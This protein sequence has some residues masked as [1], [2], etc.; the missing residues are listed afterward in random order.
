ME[1]RNRES[2]HIIFSYYRISR[3]REFIESFRAERSWAALQER[4][5]VRRRDR[6]RAIG[7]R[8]SA[9]AVAVLCLGGVLDAVNGGDI[10]EERIDQSVRRIFLVKKQM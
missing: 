5:R 7:R 2:K 6:R 3:T 1:E 4:L 8:L 10:A 9:A